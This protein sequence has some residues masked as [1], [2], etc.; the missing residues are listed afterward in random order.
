MSVY[1]EGFEAVRMIKK[2]SR[3]VWPDSADYGVPVKKG[4]ALWN[5]TKQLVNWYG[6][7]NTRVQEN[8]LG[9]KSVSQEI[10]LMDEWNTGDIHRYTVCFVTVSNHKDMDGIVYLKLTFLKDMD[11]IVYLK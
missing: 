1:K 8:Y 3:Q 4:D 2:A 9:G 5:M 7:E 10:E 6:V 11:G